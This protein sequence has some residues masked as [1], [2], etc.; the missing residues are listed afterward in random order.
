ML[1]VWD[2]DVQPLIA[3]VL[4]AL[5]G[6]VGLILVVLVIVCPVFAHDSTQCFRDFAGIDV[7]RHIQ[8]L[9]AALRS[10]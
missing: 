10:R 4:S 5:V 8:D 9:D 1:F 6:H 2:V 3:T 7:G